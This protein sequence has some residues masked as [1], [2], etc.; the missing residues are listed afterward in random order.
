M[1][2]DVKEIGNLNSPNYDK[3]SNDVAAQ[4]YKQ[5]EKKG[6]RMFRFNI[7]VGYKSRFFVVG[8]GIFNIVLYDEN[9]NPI[10]IL[11]CTNFQDGIE[12]KHVHSDKD[13]RGKEIGFKVYEEVSKQIHEPIYSGEY[14]TPNSKYAIW[15][16]LIANHPD[17]VVAF[18]THENRD[19]PLNNVE[20]EIY[21]T[22][23]YRLKLLPL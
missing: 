13:I 15:D 3:F 18:D 23:Q 5:N 1:K 14:Q 7:D 22:N 10:F 20:S 8:S 4:L 6:K 9:N 17:K 19:I 21:G 2:K 11:H 16:K 12:V